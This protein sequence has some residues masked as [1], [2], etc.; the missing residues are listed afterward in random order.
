VR[1][2][3]AAAGVDATITPADFRIT[4]DCAASLDL[5]ATC[6]CQKW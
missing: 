3:V 5:L 2:N 4:D 1:R 6:R